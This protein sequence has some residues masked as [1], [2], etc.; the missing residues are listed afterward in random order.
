MNGPNFADGGADS[1]PGTLLE[2]LPMTSAERLAEAVLMFHRG[3][4]WTQEDRHRWT[5]LTGSEDATTRALCDFARA[6]QARGGEGS[7]D[8]ERAARDRGAR[9]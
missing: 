8:Q 1:A 4:Q 3:G 6:I 5:A 7:G 2:Q 9:A